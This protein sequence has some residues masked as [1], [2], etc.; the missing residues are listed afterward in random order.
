MNVICQLLHIPVYIM[1]VRVFIGYKKDILPKTH[2]FYDPTLFSALIARD[3][4]K[5]RGKI[6][7]NCY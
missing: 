3:F 7:R 2:H 5:I 1:C 4:V 6:T